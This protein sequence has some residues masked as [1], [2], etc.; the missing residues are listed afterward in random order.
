MK[1]K[2]YLI[3]EYLLNPEDSINLFFFIGPDTGLTDERVTK[4]SKA[5]KIDNNNPFN[6]SRI[7]QSEL[8]KN[9]TKLLDE[10]LTYSLSSEKRFVFLKIYSESIDGFETLRD[11][12]LK[13]YGV[14]TLNDLYKLNTLVEVIKILSSDSQFKNLDNSDREI[15]LKGSIEDT[16]TPQTLS[17]EIAELGSE[18][19][20]LE[21]KRKDKIKE[22]AES[23]IEANKEPEFLIEHLEIEELSLIEEIQDLK[24]EYL[25]IVLGIFLALKQLNS[26]DFNNIDFL[27]IINEILPNINSQFT[28]FNLDNETQQ[29]SLGYNNTRKDFVRNPNEFSQGEI[30][31]IALS[32]RLAIQKASSKNG[33]I[34]PFIYDDCTEELDNERE[35]N[36]FSELFTLADKNQIIYL[37]H[38]Y[39]LV[40]R[41][42]KLSN[43]CNFIELENYRNL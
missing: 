16:I 15:L 43:N 17:D 12:K 32:L 42:K 35:K 36:F 30:A 28:S 34:F 38:N 10:A 21:T 37:T 11:N 9:P 25:A 23:E 22:L 6:V 29:V 5:L 31:S 40:E 7:D 2:E 14:E 24:K 20:D 39:E 4:L 18:I 33:Y 1:I 8:E 19:S 27:Q 3:D 13:E 26:S 41:L